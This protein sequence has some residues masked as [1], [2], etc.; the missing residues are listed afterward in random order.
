MTRR[1]YLLSLLIFISILFTSFHSNAITISGFILDENSRPLP[2]SSI[3]IKGSTKGTTA[4]AEGKYA[5]DL[6]PG[7]YTIVSTHVGYGKEEETIEVKDEPVSIS[8]KLYPVKTEIKDVVIKSNAE[9][10]AYAII[11]KAIK[12]RKEHL[13]EVKQWQVDVYMKGKIKTVSM[14]KKILGMKIET[15]KN[16]IDS[17]GKGVLYLSESFTKYS[18][19]LPNDFK[20]EIISSKV[21]GNSKGFSFNSPQSMEMNLYENNISID[22]LSDRGFISPISNN[23]LNYYKYKY[24]G[25]FYEDG[26]EINKIRVTAKRKYEP[27]FTSGYINIIEG[28]WRIHSVDILL[29]K[30]S[31]IEFVDSFHIQQQMLPLPKGFWMP[32]QT[33]FLATFGILGIKANADFTAV[34]SDYNIAPSFKKDFFGKVIRTADTSANKKSMA[35]WDS[36]RPVPLTIEERTDY[37][38]K[39]S[40][41]KKINNPKYQDSLDRKRNK[42]TVSGIFLAGVIKVKRSKKMIYALNPLIESVSYNTVE[43]AVINIT[44][45]ITHYADTNTYHINPGIRYG[46][47]NKRLQAFIDVD[48]TFGNNF[49]KRWTLTLG[50]G[51]KMVQIN[52]QNPIDVFSNT[53]STLIYTNNLMKLYEKS[54]GTIGVNRKMANGLNVGISFNYEQRHLPENTDTIYKWSSYKNR[55][56]T[57]NYPVE[58]PQ[59]LFPDHNAFLSNININYQPGQKFIE[60]PNRRISIG[61]N[62]PLFTFNYTHGWKNLLG[63]DVD[64]DKWS[65]RIQDEMNFKLAGAFNYRVTVGGFLNNK[66]VFLPDYY[67]FIGN[68]STIAS[69]YLESFQLAPYYR[70]SN[71]ERFF[72]SGN[73]EHHFNGLLTNKIPLIRNLKWNLVAA[74][75]AF[76]VNKN[77]YYVEVSGGIENIL[78]IL[79]V[80]FVWGYRPD[81]SKPVYGIIVGLTG[82]FNGANK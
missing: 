7:K 10:P 6:L 30:T 18:R 54:Y 68:Q 69:P 43:G 32:Q 5:L 81:I 11:R 52:P 24:E 38:K 59:G 77:K 73:I 63:S 42:I 22:G 40:L 50:G 48:K 1:P 35:Y 25:T 76:Y 17:L 70:Y 56:F 27:C 36:L 39:D 61:S 16:I 28:S 45:R 71:A 51:R 65:L 14:P 75:N 74:S 19:K 46:F 2:F 47:S 53:I 33:A 62:W 4:N 3:Y 23:A 57:S 82:L 21:S 80:D 67:H 31:H 79:R 12:A 60:Y 34:F 15:D 9:D 55:H 41:E 78:K 66:K 20:E 64:F 29:T 13:N 44:P 58:L 72:I 8:F 26:I 37:E 49:Y